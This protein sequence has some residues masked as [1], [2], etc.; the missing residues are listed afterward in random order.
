[1]EQHLE[2]HKQT[3]ADALPISRSETRN[4]LVLAWPL[5]ISNSFTTL[6][7]TID[8]LFLSKLGSEVVGGTLFAVTL[9]WTPFV[10]FHFTANYVTTFVAQYTGAGR[11]ERVGPAVW[12]GIW[13]SVIAGTLWIGVAPFAS[14]I[15]ALADHSP[16]L[17]AI[18]ATYFACLC[19]MA[20]PSLIV[21]SI[22]GFFSGRGESRTILWINGTG[23][24]VNAVL[25]WVM[26]FGEFGLPAMGVAG[27]GWA[28]VIAM[29]VS[30]LL[31]LGLMLRKKFREEHATLSGWRFDPD[32]FKR[33][34]RYGIP[35]GFQWTLDM[36]A[37]SGFIMMMGWFGNAQISAT[38]FAITINNF[39]FIPMLGMGQAVS[40]LVG[41]RLTEG[42]PDRAER[43]A[44]IGFWIAGLYMLIVGSLYVLAPSA[45]IDPFRSNASHEEWSEI[46]GQVRVLLWFVAVYSLFDA[47]N[48][49]FSFA[50]RGAGDTLFV[51]YVSLFLAWPVMVLPTWLAWKYGWSMYW[52]WAF[53]SIYIGTQAT[54]FLLRFRGGKWKSMRVIESSIRI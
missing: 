5:I 28:T 20:L 4:L 22:S 24:I 40:I 41:Q 53:A 37:F 36:S 50:L 30:A 1:M 44:Y 27:A 35:S 16:Q 14:Q 21:A 7:I 52:A 54:C 38:G 9:F 3:D 15:V 31:A 51:T 10:L 17:Q 39:A 29:W 25:A 13:F 2:S 48:I 47:M 6:Q 33:V 11:S 49:V 26:I 45:F 46:A 8:R 18:E 43:S 42:F 32:L 23:L 19:W 34:M 12:Q